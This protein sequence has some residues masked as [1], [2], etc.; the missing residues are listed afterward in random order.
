MTIGII[1]G[2]CARGEPPGE[3]RLQA[4]VAATAAGGTLRLE[5]GTYELSTP[6][7]IDHDITIIGSS[8]GT[9]IAVAV[10]HLEVHDRVG[11]RIAASRV[12]LTGFEIGTDDDRTTLLQVIQGKAVVTDMRLVGGWTGVEFSPISTGDVR[13]SH[14]EASQFGVIVNGSSVVVEDNE[15]EQHQEGIVFSNGSNSTAHANTISSSSNAILVQ[16]QAD[17]RII[18]NEITGC[19]GGIAFYEDARGIATA[20]TIQGNQWGID[21]RSPGPV[22]IAD[23]TMTANEAA[24]QFWVTGGTGEVT[25]NSCTDN[26][27]DIILAGPNV[28]NLRDNDCTTDNG[29]A[30]DPS[31]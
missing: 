18:A 25:G 12:E 4:A 22:T 5:A 21:V 30:H 23:N 27:R 2:G 19:A 14:F 8:D 1:L 3:L 24:I 31:G 28:P 13:G 10:D 9:K 17:P 26:G 16:E 20:N 6:V 15:F 29:P 7:Q 11:I